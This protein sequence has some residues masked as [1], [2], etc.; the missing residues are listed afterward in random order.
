MAGRK[1]E[2]GKRMNYTVTVF[3]G[4]YILET[5]G[6]KT[7]YDARVARLELRKKYPVARIE[8]DEVK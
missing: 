1:S 4:D 8:I 2:R 7:Y 3:S 5:H 6:Y